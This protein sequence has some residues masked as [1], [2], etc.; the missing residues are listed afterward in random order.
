MFPSAEPILL[1]GLS[2]GS[3]M[4]KTSE[5]CYQGGIVLRCYQQAELKSTP[6]IRCQQIWKLCLRAIARGN[7]S[8]QI[9]P[10]HSPPVHPRREYFLKRLRADLHSNVGRIPSKTAKYR[11]GPKPVIFAFGERNR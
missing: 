4:D 7:A 6:L 1:L 5:W 3:V 11:S 2:F 8:L 10:L 9:Q